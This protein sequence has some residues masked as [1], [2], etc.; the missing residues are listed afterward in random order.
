MYNNYPITFISQRGRTK[1]TFGIRDYNI[2][3]LDDD[4]IKSIMDERLR[5]KAEA[6]QQQE[7]LASKRSLIQGWP[8]SCHKDFIDVANILVDVAPAVVGHPGAGGAAVA[9]LLHPDQ[10]KWS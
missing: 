1:T 4:K 7:L 9:Q 6:T 3:A 10:H 2:R 5:G 8:R